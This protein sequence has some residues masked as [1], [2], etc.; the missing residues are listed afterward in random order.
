MAHITL[1]HRARE[2]WH[3]LSHLDARPDQIA[4]GFSI[5][6]VAGLLPL[7]PSPI[8]V[9]TAVAWLLERNVVAAVAG[10]AVAILYTPLLPLIWLAEY[11]LGTL[12]LPVRH[13]LEWDQ[14]RLWDALHT[15]WDVYAAMFVGSI[16]I[17]APIT[18]LTYMVV[19]RV[20]ERKSRQ[21]QSN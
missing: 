20:A 18:V 7:N 12:L 21:R 15:G 1:K 16:I 9:A 10:A 13:P 14:L 3:R 2:I 6:V 5:G 17:A 11:R 19:R 4:A 8:I